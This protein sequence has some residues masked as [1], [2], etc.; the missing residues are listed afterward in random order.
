[1][2]FI[3][4]LIY[5]NQTGIRILRHVLFWLIHVLS[6][7]VVV[8]FYT[9]IVA[10]EVYYVLLVIP[11]AM[12]TTYFIMYFILPRF[13]TENSGGKIFLWLIL[14]LIALGFGLR[15]Y[16]FYILLPF[17]DSEEPGAFEFWNFA[18]VINEV[19]YWLGIICMATAIKL[20]KS[21]TELHKKNDQLASEKR[22]AELNFLKLQMHPHFLFNTLNTLYSET[23]QNSEKAGQVVM[24]LSSLLRFMLEEC[25]KPLITLEKEIRMIKD[26]IDLEK[27]RHGDRLNVNMSVPKN[28]LELMI[29]PLLFLPFIENSFKHSLANIRG[30]V[31]IDIDIK[32][33]ST[34][35]TLMV[36]N[37]HSKST[38]VNGYSLGK[39]I[40][41]IKRQLELLYDKDHSLII[42]DSGEKYKVSLVIPVKNS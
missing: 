38:K 1:M 29:S 8:S 36:E 23:I 28:D 30:E 25:N 12:I 11:L 16:K 18:K 27:L 2:N 17:L 5:S 42:N 6:W 13:S 4:A 3:D 39:G 20:I 35:L 37:D 40:A 34:N 19:F 33:T 21:K 10:R 26:Y 24:H 22:I 32:R 41:N 31:N 14:V 9:P 15:Y 7:L